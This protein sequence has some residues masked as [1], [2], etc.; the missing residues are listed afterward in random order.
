MSVGFILLAFQTQRSNV[1]KRLYSIFMVFQKH[2]IKCSWSQWQMLLMW[3]YEKYYIYMVCQN[4][5]GW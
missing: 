5:F 1:E 3:I 4:S 2:M